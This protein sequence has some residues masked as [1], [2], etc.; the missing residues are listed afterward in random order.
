LPLH[1]SIVRTKIPP[2]RLLL[3]LIAGP[4][5]CAAQQP[6]AER[7]ATCIVTRVADGDSFRCNDGRRIRLIGIDSPEGQQLF[8]PSAR[9]ALLRLIPTGTLV[10]LEPDVRFNDQYG[11]SLAYVWSGPTL[12]NEAMVRDGW[13]VLYTIP[14]NVKYAE[15]LGRAQ[16]EARARGA[17]LWSQN[18]FN[19]LPSDFR[20]KRCLN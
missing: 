20:R 17:G 7:N 18:G 9:A 19:C 16:K 6:A 4:T 11:R 3:L 8:G 13:A 5:A 1:S 14:P 10:R 2:I 15:R 12:V